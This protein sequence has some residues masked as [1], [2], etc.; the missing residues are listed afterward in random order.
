MAGEG[1]S[2][3]AGT[4]EDTIP[5]DE[6]PAPPDLSHRNYDEIMEETPSGGALSGQSR[7]RAWLQKAS[8]DA[9]WV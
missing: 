6:E 3:A 4:M 2:A 1:D 5:I 9:P 7:A 8:A